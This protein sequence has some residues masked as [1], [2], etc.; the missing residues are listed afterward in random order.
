MS[1]HQSYPKPVEEG[2]LVQF[3]VY[4][5]ASLPFL[6]QEH[7]IGRQVSK[8]IVA[9]DFDDDCATDEDMQENA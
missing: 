8:S 3:P 4:E 2:T 9:A 1:Q 7:D 5:D 6:D